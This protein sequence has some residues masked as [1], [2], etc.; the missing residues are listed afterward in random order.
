ME[1]PFFM[2]MLLSGKW[3]Q[4]DQELGVNL[5]GLAF[6]ARQSVPEGDL[7]AEKQYS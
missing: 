5:G 2:E 1:T 4:G 3:D 7:V 6:V